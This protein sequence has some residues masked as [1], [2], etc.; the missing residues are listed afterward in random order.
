MNSLSVTSYRGKD[1]P[2]ILQFL[3]EQTA[4]LIGK[5]G[6]AF[7]CKLDTVKPVAH[8]LINNFMKKQKHQPEKLTWTL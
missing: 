1:T 2:L 6:S 8:C 4:L 3:G 5:N 7:V